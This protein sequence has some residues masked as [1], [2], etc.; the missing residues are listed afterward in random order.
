[1]TTNL[2]TYPP[3][4]WRHLRDL[5]VAAGFVD[6]GVSNGIQEL[7]WP[8]SGTVDAL[9]LATNPPYHDQ[10]VANVLAALRRAARRGSMADNV[11]DLLNDE[12]AEDRHCS[13]YPECREERYVS[14]LLAS[15][16][17]EEPVGKWV[18]GCP[19]CGVSNQPA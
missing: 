18:S 7:R 15:V 16:K 2:R 1:M 14:D 4:T 8:D 17:A 11:L 13:N 6:G 5:M 12:P 19:D 9:Y 3:D 10:E